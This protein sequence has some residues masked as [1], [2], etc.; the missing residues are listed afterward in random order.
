MDPSSSILMCHWDINN[1]WLLHL[2]V[3]YVILI[4][5]YFPKGPLE[6]GNESRF[7]TTLLEFNNFCLALYV[8]CL[9]RRSSNME[10]QSSMEQAKYQNG[11]FLN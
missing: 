11:F 8:W 7:K 6:K 9:L 5:F 2:V 1:G 4:H 10:S 3:R